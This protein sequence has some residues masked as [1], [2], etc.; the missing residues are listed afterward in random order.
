MNS[1]MSTGQRYFQRSDWHFW[2]SMSNYKFS[3]VFLTLKLFK[4]LPY[5]SQMR[6]GEFSNVYLTLLFYK[7]TSEMSNCKFSNVYLTMILSKIWLTLLSMSNCKFSNVFLTLT[8]FKMSIWHCCFL[9]TLHK[10]LTVSSQ[11]SIWHWHF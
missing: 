7:H 4:C 11:M 10:C 8:L 3:N 6:N 2:V 5:F 1:Q 9:N